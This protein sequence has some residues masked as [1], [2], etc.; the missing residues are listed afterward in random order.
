MEKE[1][2]NDYL[3]QSPQ[4]EKTN[5]LDDIVK[6]H[7]GQW[8]FKKRGEINENT[9]PELTTEQTISGEPTQP[10]VPT[11]P[12]DPLRRVSA[13]QRKESLDEYREQFMTAPKITDRQPVFIS[14]TTRDRIDEI[15]RRFG[16]RKMSVSGFLE[17]IAHHHLDLYNEDI[18]QW[19]RL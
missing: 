5:R 14:R 7:I 10:T 16:E 19:K 6:E 9:E 8:N 15:V 4:N 2:A 1:K 12:S 3:N 11:V 17:N 18:E 13:K